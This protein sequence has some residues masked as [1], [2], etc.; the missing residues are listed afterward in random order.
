MENLPHVSSRK[1]KNA[2]LVSV[3]KSAPLT[4]HIS[5]WYWWIAV[6]RNEVKSLAYPPA[7]RARNGSRLQERLFDEISRS[8][9]LLKPIA[10]EDISD[11]S[12]H[13]TKATTL[14]KCFMYLSFHLVASKVHTTAPAFNQQPR[15]CRQTRC[16]PLGPR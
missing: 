16:S 10:S 12:F 9:A 6:L 2:P 5:E 8:S 3:Q 14:D 11:N 13:L 15:R 4:C 7:T 1:Q